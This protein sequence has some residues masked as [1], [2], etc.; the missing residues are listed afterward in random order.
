MGCIDSNGIGYT[1]GSG[2][3]AKLGQND[4]KDCKLPTQLD[5]LKNIKIQ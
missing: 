3:K 4:V 1:W 2:Y 5:F